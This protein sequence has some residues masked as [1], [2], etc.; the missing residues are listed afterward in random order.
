LL[1]GLFRCSSQASFCAIHIPAWRRLR[2]AMMR[3]ELRNLRKSFGGVHALRPI[4]LSIPSGAKVGLVGPNGSGK[5]TLIR[6]LMGILRADGDAALDGMHPLRNR[7]A[8]ASKIVYVPQ[9]APQLGA[10]VREIVRVVADLREIPVS[11]VRASALRL[12]VDLET[13]GDRPF[14]T[15]SG[16]TKQKVLIALALATPASLVV[17]DEPTASLDTDARED[18]FRLFADV[19]KSATLLLCS[20]RIEEMRHLIDRIVA[21]N[22][23]RVVYD[24]PADT[25]LGRAAAS[26]MQL[27]VG[28]SGDRA[29]L[30]AHGFTEGI[31]G[32]WAKTV[33]NAERVELLLAVS[34]H[35]GP[36]L[37]DVVVRDVERIDASPAS[38]TARQD[39]A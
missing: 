18:F 36:S 16:G 9:V 32:W 21:L 37:R 2:G 31:G 29:W 10:S 14:G 17:L 7:A 1:A 35:L 24:G 15:L 39:H 30:A 23:G 20:H 38:R 28:T 22:E 13:I 3:I 4:T 25:Y 26:V 8:V 12:H 27:S 19:S 5:S 6:V 33:T 34:S 11:A